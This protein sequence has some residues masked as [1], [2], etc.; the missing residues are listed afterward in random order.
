MNVSLYDTLMQCG[1][2]VI[3]F[4][5]KTRRL[6]IGN[7]PDGVLLEISSGKKLDT[8][9]SWQKRRNIIIAKSRVQM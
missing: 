5:D 7:R 3:T 6:F 1:I 9:K 4:E 2:V 8:M